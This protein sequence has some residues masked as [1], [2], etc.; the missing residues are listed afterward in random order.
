MVGKS[1]FMFSKT[2][3]VRKLCYNIVKQ[4]FYDTIVLILI[5]VSTFLLTL[6]NPNLDEEGDL[7]QALSVCDIVLT[8]L[9]T[10]ECIINIILFGL[11][12][13]G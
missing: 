9:F 4:S 10:L 1:L 11:I 6:D 7:A 2:N 3:W 12:C 8:T 5:T 13:N